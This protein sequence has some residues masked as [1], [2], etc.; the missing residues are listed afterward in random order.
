MFI[1]VITNSA[2]GK[3]YIGQHKRNNLKKY[4]QTKLS[5]AAK[6]RGG[7]SRLYNSMRK[8]PK[9]VWSIEPLME[10]ETK[11]ELD[12]LETLLIALYDTR[13]PEVGYNICKGGEG[14]TGKHTTE[15]CSKMSA[16]MK[17]VWSDLDYKV[18]T[19]A[20]LRRAMSTPEHRVKASEA[21]SK[22]WTD[23][24]FRSKNQAAIREATS[25]PEYRIKQAVSQKQVWSNP[26]YR[27]DMSVKRA[28]LFQVRWADTEKRTEISK[29]RS[30]STTKA[31]STPETRARLLRGIREATKKRREMGEVIQQRTSYATYLRIK[32]MRTN[33]ITWKEIANV[34]GVPVGT[35]SAILHRNENRTF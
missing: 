29:A 2:T 7:Q 34:L 1:Y 18:K 27:T 6:L 20:S 24:E 33:G 30:E 10:V 35:A 13:N 21:T 19:T 14:V 32:E 28:N 15:T 22:C 9:E 12:R 17:R 16:A 23:P 26:E 5:D 31:W 4:L 8:H 11:A 25:A 3:I